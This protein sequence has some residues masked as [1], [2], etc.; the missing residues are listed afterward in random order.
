[1]HQFFVER[2]THGSRNGGN[3]ASGL[4]MPNIWV[5]E[6]GMAKQRPGYGLKNTVNAGLIA[7]RHFTIGFVGFVGV[8]R[9]PSEVNEARLGEKFLHE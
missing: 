2:Q 8:W 4:S 7:Y 1:M 5:F 3:N 6:Q 9:Q